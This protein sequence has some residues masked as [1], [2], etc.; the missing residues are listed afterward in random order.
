MTYL[1]QGH[2]NSKIIA[3]LKENGPVV[4]KTCQVTDENGCSELPNN[5]NDKVELSTEI[6]ED[7]HVDETFPSDEMELSA[8]V[9]EE[10]GVDETFPSDESRPS[11]KARSV[12][13]EE[14][15]SG[16]ADDGGFCPFLS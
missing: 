14:F 16:E 4:S 13:E 9:E 1:L 10:R 3:M 7:G 12:I 8:E 6:K 11:K 2:A 15:G 5:T